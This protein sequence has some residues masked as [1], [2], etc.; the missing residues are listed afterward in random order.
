MSSRTGETSSE[1]IAA[2]ANISGRPVTGVECGHWR[3]T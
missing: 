2:P 1:A 3:P